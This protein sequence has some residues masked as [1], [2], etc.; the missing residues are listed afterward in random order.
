MLPLRKAIRSVKF[1]AAVF[2][3]LL[4][5]GLLVLKS[6]ALPADEV[7][8]T[9]FLTRLNQLEIKLAQFEQN[10]KKIME[11]QEKILKQIDT[12]QAWKHKGPRR[13]KN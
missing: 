13:K 11:N 9:S 3:I 12:L 6:S 7:S 5:G 8:P 1:K 4:T 10:E 2:L